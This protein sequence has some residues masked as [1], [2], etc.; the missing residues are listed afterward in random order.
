MAIK[1]GE[2]GEGEEEEEED[3][4]DVDERMRERERERAEWREEWTH[5]LASSPIKVTLAM[6]EEG[7]EKQY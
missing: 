6:N 3:K 4:I 2:M 1:V 5:N 7:D